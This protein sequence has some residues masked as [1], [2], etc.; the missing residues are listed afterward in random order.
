MHAG[1]FFEQY[2]TLSRC[3]NVSHFIE[4]FHHFFFVCADEF[5]CTPI[6]RSVANCNEQVFKQNQLSSAQFNFT[7]KDV[8]IAP[9]D[10]CV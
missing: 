6:E 7:D 10:T 9:N 2:A 1:H 8:S 3:K 4:N 5:E